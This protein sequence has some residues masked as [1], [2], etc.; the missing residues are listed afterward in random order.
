MDD[1][2][3][4]EHDLNSL[5]ALKVLTQRAL[6]GLRTDSASPDL[7]YSFILVYLTSFSFRNPLQKAPDLTANPLC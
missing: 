7:H 3:Q 2:I 1:I 5:T 4:W 6:L